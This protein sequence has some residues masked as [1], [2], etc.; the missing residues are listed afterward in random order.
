MNKRR[1]IIVSVISAAM[2]AG[3]VSLGLAVTRAG[4][5]PASPVASVRAQPVT[6]TIPLAAPGE[7]LAPPPANASPAMTAQAAMVKA[8]NAPSGTAIPSN[9]TVYLGLYTLP[10]GDAS[11]CQQPNENCSGDTIVGNTVYTDYQVLAYGY[12][13]SECGGSLADGC[14]AWEFVDANTGADLGGIR[15]RPTAP[16]A[17]APA[18]SP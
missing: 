6:S 7:V 4:A 3:G 16:S 9:V 2:V 5:S 10:I 14:V 17:P 8:L 13:Y 11:V 18:P 15:P 1:T 12:E